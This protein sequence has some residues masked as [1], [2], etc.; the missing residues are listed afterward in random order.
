MYRT[1][2]LLLSVSCLAAPIRFDFTFLSAQTGASAVGFI[3]F[4]ETLLTNPGTATFA[5]PHP[6]V[7][8]LQVTVTGAG[9][10]NGTFVIDDFDLVEWDTNGGLL[11]F[12]QEL[13]GQPTSQ[14]PWGPTVPIS[15][16]GGEFNL[17]AGFVTD[18]ES[19][20]VLDGVEAP[21]GVFWFAVGANGGAADIMQLVSMRAGGSVPTLG[22]WGLGA[23]LIGLAV[24]AMAMRRVRAAA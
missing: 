3:V 5:L 23:L 7:L 22:T 21:S 1:A 17:F 9:A 2:F 20:T 12:G 13:V 19:G 16:E 11:D 8:D 15:G 14:Q 18:Y 10:G 6:G 4:E 24:M